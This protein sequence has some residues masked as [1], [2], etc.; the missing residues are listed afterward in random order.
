M[1]A[2]VWQFPVP[3]GLARL[4]FSAPPTVQQLDTLLRYID[5]AAE[6]ANAEA[7]RLQVASVTAAEANCGGEGLSHAQ[8]REGEGT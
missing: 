1:M 7:T 2:E 8:E 6:A 4:V 3:G 5:I